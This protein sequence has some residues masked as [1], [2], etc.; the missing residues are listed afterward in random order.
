MKK[1]RKSLRKYLIDAYKTSEASLEQ[2]NQP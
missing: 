1:M 2:K